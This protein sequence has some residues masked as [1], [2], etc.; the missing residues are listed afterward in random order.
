MIC[1]LDLTSYFALSFMRGNQLIYCKIER[2]SFLYRKLPEFFQEAF[3]EMNITPQQIT[4]FVVVNGPGSFTGIRTS[5]SFVQGLA[6]GSKISIHLI[7]SLQVLKCLGQSEEPI[8]WMPASKGFIY[9]G[10]FKDSQWQ[11]EFCSE[12]TLSQFASQELVGMEILFKE[13]PFEKAI[14]EALKTSAVDSDFVKPNYIQKPLV[15]KSKKN[16]VKS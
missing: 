9:L 14:F 12:S 2:E 15:S 1:Y 6:F 8:V 7:S 3:N 16:F 4:K 11:E 13:Y 5:I 10:S